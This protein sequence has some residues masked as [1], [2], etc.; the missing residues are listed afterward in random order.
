VTAEPTWDH[1][2]AAVLENQVAA[3]DDMRGRCPA[4]HDETL[5]WT[6]FRHA[7]VLRVALDHGTFSNQVSSHLQV[8]NGMDLPEHT[9]YRAIVDRYFTPEVVDAFEAT[10]RAIAADLVDRLPMATR[11]DAMTSLAEPFALRV[12][13]E[14][15][16]WPRRLERPLRAWT[17][18]NRAATLARNP[19][20]TAALAEEFDGYITA[21]LSERRTL[22]DAAPD[23]LT[24]R[25]MR[26]Q[27]DGRPLTDDELVSILRNW[28]V[29]ELGTIAACVGIVVQAL[30]A[31]PDVQETLRRYPA[32]IGEAVDEMLR[33]E[34]PFVASRRVVTHP[35]T[36]AGRRFEPGDR[37]TA[38]WAS[39]NRDEAVFGDPDQF[40]LGR[41]EHDNLLYGAGV[42]VC[43]GAPL[44]R[45]ELR[46]IVEELLAATSRI[47]P[48]PDEPPVRAAYPAGGF[49]DVPVRLTAPT[50]P[51]GTVPAPAHRGADDE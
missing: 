51:P 3:Y 5:G 13:S 42:H 33:I 34:P 10:C 41:P 14:H 17:A 36:L 49:T 40:L 24:T 22:G 4:A 9:G 35:T 47:E 44:A 50:P 31:R 30:A 21:L 37:L 11:V 43:P 39:A 45:L 19:Q 29:G 28:T 8:P 20:A 18:R 12:Q 25:L 26:E 16:G 15:L 38:L 2:S 23:D 27:I 46:V 7:D 32:T 1:R 6:L 48:W